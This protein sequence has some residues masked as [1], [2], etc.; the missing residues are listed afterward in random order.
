[1]E[2]EKVL[3]MRTL[4]FVPTAR[5]VR[6]TG[7]WLTA[8]AV[9][10]GFVLVAV[11]T[12]RDAGWTDG[13][14]ALGSWVLPMMLLAGLILLWREAASAV[15]LPTVLVPV[16]LAV[17]QALDVHAWEQVRSEVGPFDA[18]TVMFLGLALAIL[19]TNAEETHVAGLAM[20]TVALAPP[21]VLFVITGGLG[22]AST[23]LAGVPV[24]VTGLLYLRA[25]A[26]R[27]REDARAVDEELGELLPMV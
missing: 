12:V 16:G 11:D 5:T 21:A 24:L 6:R 7:F 14:V 3:A 9:T 23:L 8:A 13:I 4:S 19:G 27:H 25:A 2:T 1:M 22:A 17:W 10:G 18:M 26:L 20:V 15:L